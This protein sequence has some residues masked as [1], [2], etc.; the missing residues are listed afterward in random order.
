MAPWKELKLF[1]MLVD[2]GAVIKND[3]GNGGKG[4]ELNFNLKKS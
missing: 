1:R 3:E 4:E 2:R